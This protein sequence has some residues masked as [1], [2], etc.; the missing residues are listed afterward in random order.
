MDTGVIQ[1][2]QVDLWTR[3]QSR[4]FSRQVTP[5]SI[6]Q[7]NK[8]NSF[9]TFM[10]VQISYICAS[11]AV[12]TSLILLYYRIFGVARGFRYTLIVAQS[13]VA[14]YFLANLFVAIFQC[15][16]VSYSCDKKISGTCIN[17]VQFD[18][19]NGIANMLTDLLILSLTFPMV[20]RL[21]IAFRQKITLTGIFLLGTL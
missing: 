19:W 7:D 6:N 1:Y 3:E 5:Q 21:K 2:M 11:M 18:R 8:I 9:Q 17:Q 14:S 13:V 20:W 16:P 4:A 12:K 15:K 10:A